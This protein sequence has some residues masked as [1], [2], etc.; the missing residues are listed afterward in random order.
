MPKLAGVTSRTTGA[1]ARGGGA[2]GAGSIITVRACGV[3]ATGI[4]AMPAR[5]A[6]AGGGS[7]L[8]AVTGSS[9]FSV[10]VGSSKFGALLVPVVRSSK[11]TGGVGGAGVVAGAG[12]AGTPNIVFAPGPAV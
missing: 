6:S 8:G 7:K 5:Y 11:S 3:V 2:A 4:G 1:I 12:A 9:K 10:V